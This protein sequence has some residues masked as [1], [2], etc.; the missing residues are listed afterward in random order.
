MSICSSTA[1]SAA[2]SSRTAARP[3][4]AAKMSGTSRGALWTIS[5]PPAFEPAR[6]LTTSIPIRYIS[7]TQSGW[8][9]FQRF[10]TFAAKQWHHF[11]ATRYFLALA[12]G[13]TVEGPVARNPRRSRIFEWDGERFVEFQA[14][15]GGWGYN[16]VHFE[17]AGQY[18]LGYA[19]H[20]SPSGL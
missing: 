14:L 19:D 13:V 2:G 3:F 17:Q 8:D 11:P 1:G 15:E 12:Q 16:W 6:V 4:P 7:T 10:P 9:P 20:I 18:F 5:R